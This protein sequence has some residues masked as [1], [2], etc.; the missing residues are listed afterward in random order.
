MPERSFHSDSVQHAGP[1]QETD[2][3]RTF[4]DVDDVRMIEGGHD[5]DLSADVDQ[6]LVIFNLLLPYGLDGNLA[7][8]T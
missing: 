4:V 3:R 5:F 8:I 1:E 6:V 7:E 2:L